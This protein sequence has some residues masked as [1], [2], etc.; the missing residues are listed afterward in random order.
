MVE[1]TETFELECETLDQDH[2]R[3]VEL[4]NSIVAMLD[5]GETENCEQKVY[6]F[7]SF[8]KGHFSREEK[9]LEKVGYPKVDKHRE[10]HKELDRKMEHLLEFARNVGSNE[11][12]RDSLKKE[13]VFFLMDDIITTDLDFKE[14]VSGQRPK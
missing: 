7:I 13:L 3:L 6:E 1:L 11:M 2:Q 10:H 5:R 14:Y 9:F 4:V 12:A 8:A